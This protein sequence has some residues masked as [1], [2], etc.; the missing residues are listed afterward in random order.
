MIPRVVQQWALTMGAAGAS[1]F[2]LWQGG[3]GLWDWA[4]NRAPVAVSC[5]DLAKGRPAAW[6]ALSDCEGDY[7]AAAYKLQDHTVVEV[8]VP[9]RAPGPDASVHAILFTKAP[10]ALAVVQQLE[11]GAVKPRPEALRVI[12]TFT[13]M[14]RSAFDASLPDQFVA[15]MKSRGLGA[16]YFV[17]DDG[18]RPE[19]LE[20]VMYVVIASGL[21]LLS[22]WL[23]SRRD[24]TPSS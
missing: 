21:A 11:D 15:S 1:V 6:L 10:K 9:L 7:A 14:A 8:F 23:F 16:E 3:H 22:L 20:S 17:L 13:G 19:L 5:A 2:M 18:R 4:R 24:P 12:G